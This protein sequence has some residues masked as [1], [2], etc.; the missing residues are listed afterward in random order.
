[1]PVDGPP[2]MDL[3]KAIFAD[4]SS[5]SPSDPEEEIPSNS[6]ENNN[7]NK[8]A[9][10]ELEKPKETNKDKEFTS[11]KKVR[12]S[13]F[14]PIK[15]EE[16]GEKSLLVM[17]A[18]EPTPKHLFRSKKNSSSN[19]SILSKNRKKKKSVI[20]SSLSFAVDSDSS[21]SD[22]VNIC[23]SYRKKVHSYLSSLKNTSHT[24]VGTNLVNNKESSN[25][26][27]SV[28]VKPEIEELPSEPENFNKVSSEPENFNKVSSEPEKF[29]KVSLEP[30]NFNKVSS[31]PE[32]FNKVSSEPENFTEEPKDHSHLKKKS[33]TASGIFSNIDFAELNCYRELM[34]EKKNTKEVGNKYNRDKKDSRTP[35]E[36]EEYDSEASTDSED[37]FGPALP[38]NFTNPLQEIM[39]KKEKT[40][41]KVNEKDAEWKEVTKTRKKEKKNRHKSKSKR[42]HKISKKEKKKRSKKSRKESSSSEE[43]SD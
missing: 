38:P 40:T 10:K 12:K 15:E 33:K 2:T 21:D 9:E 24:A 41:K 25:F 18:D 32:N 43:S 39:R 7:N 17:A 14:E 5:D 36:S 4:S 30:D 23:S 13:R 16:T 3:F 28:E 29:N 34:N 20:K 6:M 42:K 31:E 19:S 1:M 37:K 35:E 8:A 22:G 11:Q 27:S 26:S